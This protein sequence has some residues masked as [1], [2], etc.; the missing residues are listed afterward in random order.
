MC[1]RWV[2]DITSPG[3]KSFDIYVIHNQSLPERRAY[4]ESGLDAHTQVNFVEIEKQ[5]PEL[6]D[7]LYVGINQLSWSSKCDGLWNSP[8]EPRLLTRG[9]I[10]CTASHFY[11]YQ[12]F[13]KNSNKEWLLVVE[14]D[15]LFKAG[16]EK[17]IQKRI[18]S[19]PNWANALF[20]GGG[21]AHHQ[22]S[23]TIGRCKNFLIKHHP[24]TNT[25]VGYLLRRELVERMMNRFHRFDLPIDYELA[26]LLMINNAVVLHD[27]PYLIAEGSKSTYESSIRN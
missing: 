18:N 22:V 27:V 11:A 25:T 6:L 23:R 14:D 16:L 21:F 5:A 8:P 2:A 20:I 1:S 3:T 9:E 7:E 26:Y 13:L 12:Q 24:A 17:R 4:L 10:A 19:M 15:A